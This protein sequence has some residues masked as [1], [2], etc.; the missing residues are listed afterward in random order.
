M[1]VSH[2]VLSDGHATPI[3][4]MFV[5]KDG[6]RKSITN[7][8]H[9]YSFHP[10]RYIDSLAGAKAVVYGSLFR[11]PFDD[12]EVIREVTETARRNGSLVFADTK[13]PNFMKLSLDDIR[14]SLPMIDYITP[15]EDEGRYWR[16]RQFPGG[17][18]FRDHS[19]K[20]YTGCAY[21]RECLRSYL[22]HCGRIRNSP[23]KQRPGFALSE[24][25]Q[26]NIIS[27]KIKG[28]N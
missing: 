24:G 2:I 1:D 14:D 15:N 27:N 20:R 5:A 6:S 11:A 3:T 23:A 21:L 10:E 13:L 7:T 8:A 25:K 4:T 26:Y 22:Q 9:R 18:R 28:R 17:L 16:R 19:R 12:P